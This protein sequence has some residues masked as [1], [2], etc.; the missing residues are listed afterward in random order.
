MS[1]SY[2]LSAAL[3]GLFAYDN[4]AVDSGIHDEALREWCINELLQLGDDGIRTIA[5]ELY[6]QDPYGP[7]DVQDFMDWIDQRM[8]R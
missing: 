5:A 4:G 6:G 1:Y 3:D 7:E 8:L 2:S